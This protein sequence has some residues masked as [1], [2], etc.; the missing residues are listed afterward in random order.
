MIRSYV[1]TVALTFIFALGCNSGSADTVTAT[2]SATDTDSEGGTDPTNDCPALEGA[3]LGETCVSSN[4]CDEGLICISDGEEKTCQFQ[5]CPTDPTTS[6]TGGETDTTSGTTTGSTGTTQGTSTSTTGEETE[7]ATQGTTGG[8]CTPYTCED[9]LEDFPSRD[10]RGCEEGEEIKP[11]QVLEAATNQVMWAWPMLIPEY[12][13]ASCQGDDEEGVFQ[14][15]DF[16]KLLPDIEGQVCDPKGDA[17]TKWAEGVVEKVTA[18]PKVVM[19]APF[20]NYALIEGGQ[21][22]LGDE[23]TNVVVAGSTLCMKKGEKVTQF[24]LDS[25]GASAATC[26][27]QKYVEGEGYVVLGE[28]FTG[29]FPMTFEQEVVAE[30]D[31][32]TP[33]RM[34][35]NGVQGDEGEASFTLE[36]EGVSLYTHSEV[37]IFA[38]FELVAP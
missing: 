38:N 7:G 16:F 30:E 25:Q 29:E 35:C 12:H 5:Y 36:T 26:L 9:F 33:V 11:V 24:T 3:N 28:A 32:C 22:I 13:E 17:C 4:G 20:D 23:N 31:G 18:F 19:S 1:T 8:V 27:L 21:I 14:K 34:R 15:A 10:G 37:Q 2:D 6:T